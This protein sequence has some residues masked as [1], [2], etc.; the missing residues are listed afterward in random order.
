[1]LVRGELFQQAQG[2]G[3]AVAPVAQHA[4][5][6]GPGVEVGRLQHELEQIDVHDVVSL[7]QPE[8]FEHVVDLDV[9]LWQ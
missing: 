4:H 9:V 5:R 1:M 7:M 8:Q 2:I 6:G 3:D